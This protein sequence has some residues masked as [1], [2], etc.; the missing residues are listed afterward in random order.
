MATN[1]GASNP[2]QEKRRLSSAATG[3]AHLRA[4]AKNAETAQA[5]VDSILG[6]ML[7]AE[8]LDELEYGEQRYLQFHA[9]SLKKLKAA[10]TA[11]IIGDDY[12]NSAMAVSD[13]FTAL[14][15]AVATATPVDHQ[16][17]AV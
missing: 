5:T 13:G 17:G 6:Q 15:F 10:L 3:Q 8:T 7:M 4:L 1:K 14:Y 12:E 9:S 2:C 11:K 16:Q